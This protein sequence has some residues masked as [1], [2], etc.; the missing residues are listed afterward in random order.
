MQGIQ[1]PIPDDARP[2]TGSDGALVVVDETTRTIYEFWQSKHTGS[3]WSA[4]FGAIN[5][6]D[7]SGWGGVGSSTGSNASRMAGVI[8]MA[9]IQQGV[10]AHAL[11]IQ[12]DNVCSSVFRSPGDQDRWDVVAR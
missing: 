12:T 5:S 3:K 4:S 6:L 2:H 8:R 9:E 11:A 7:G 1:V 10:I